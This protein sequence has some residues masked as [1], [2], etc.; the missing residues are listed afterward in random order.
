MKIVIVGAGPAGLSF[1][2]FIKKA[3]RNHSVQVLERREPDDSL[4]WGVTLSS[5]NL[6]L[7]DYDL[8][9]HKVVDVSTI[10]YAGHEY[11]ETP[12]NLVTI[13][14]DALISFL[15]ERCLSVG[16]DIRFN[17]PVKS[18]GDI[19]M[20][21]LDLI[22]GADGVNSV[23]RKGYAE[24]FAPAM[25]TS[26]LSHLWLATPKLFGRAI[27]ASFRD[28]NGALFSGWGYQFS[29]Q[30]SSFIVESTSHGLE[31]LGLTAPGNE[32]GAR[33]IELAFRS[34]LGGQPLLTHGPIHA[35][36]FVQIKNRRWHHQRVVLIGDAAHTTHYSKGYGT[37]HA[38]RDAMSLSAHLSRSSDLSSAL[39]SFERERMPETALNQS[40]AMSSHNWYHNVLR[41]HERGSASAVIDAIHEVEKQI[42]RGEC[43]Q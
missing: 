30:L 43:I 12:V 28:Y 18:L 32:E 5:G 3:C 29:D 14:R 39:V 9:V 37:E 4:G 26:A 22:V 41:G 33:R 20:S 35:S 16:V 36:K 2:Y 1:A 13:S 25:T 31:A 24:Y 11:L 15:R 17:A 8:D 10:S 21:R 7:L 6:G 40:R 27:I 34:E 42:E 19:D 23:V 38:I